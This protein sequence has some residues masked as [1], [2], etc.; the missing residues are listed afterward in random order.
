MS[1]TD[2][3]ARGTTAG[4]RQSWPN[5]R[6]DQR[7][8]RPD[9]LRLSPTQAHPPWRTVRSLDGQATADQGRARD[10]LGQPTVP[11]LVPARQPSAP[12]TPGLP[13]ARLM[14]AGRISSVCYSLTKIDDRGRLADRSLIRALQWEPG[15]P[16]EVT[17]V[18]EAVVLVVSRGD[19]RRAIN[20][21][22]HLRLPASVRHSCGLEPGDRVLLAGYRDRQI[23][24]AYTMAALD[25]MILGWHSSTQGDVRR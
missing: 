22:G 20:G 19:G 3:P 23:V 1:T 2:L 9:S 10:R 5:A 21:Q 18:P 17:V 13:V 24:V 25:A 6:D 15:H 14:A 7:T 4:R 8:S 16:I 11:A 12:H